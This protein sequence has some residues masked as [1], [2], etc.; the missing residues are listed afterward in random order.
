MIRTQAKYLLLVTDL[1]LHTKHK[2]T[3]I[4]SP[5]KYLL[6][7]FEVEAWS[8]YVVRPEKIS[9]KNYPNNH[10]HHRGLCMYAVRFLLIYPH[11]LFLIIRVI[12]NINIVIIIIIILIA[13]SACSDAS[14]LDS[15]VRDSHAQDS[16]SRGRLANR[17]SPP[18]TGDHHIG[19]GNGDDR[20][21]AMVVIVNMI[22]VIVTT[23]AFVIFFS[24]PGILLR[25][26]PVR[27]TQQVPSCRPA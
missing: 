25:P 16:N 11:V 15:D 23:V 12:L 21:L 17:Q 8:L 2:K 14:C 26:R 4:E 3:C 20:V 13:T 6:H 22:M 10:H 19:N 5:T 9:S 18:A 7:L 24:Q 1:S 27:R